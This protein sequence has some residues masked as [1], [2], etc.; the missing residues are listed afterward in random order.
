MKAPGSLGRPSTR[1]ARTCTLLRNQWRTQKRLRVWRDRSTSTHLHSL[2]EWKRLTRAT[3][4]VAL[5]TAP[6][7]F[8]ILFD[9]EHFG[10]LAA[11]IVTA[12]AVIVFRAWSRSSPA[13]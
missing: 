2:R 5:L 6:A 3:T 9:T 8:F 13:S 12:V 11:L 7:F 1:R 10:V 4:F